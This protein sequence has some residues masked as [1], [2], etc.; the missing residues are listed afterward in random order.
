MTAA[1]Q[2]ADDVE[3]AGRR[4]ALV[5]RGAVIEE[6]PAS[7]TSTAVAAD[8]LRLSLPDMLDRLGGREINEL[9]VEAGPR[10]AGAL[11]RQ[12]LVDELILYVAPKLLGPQARPLVEMSELRSLPE[13]P[14]FMVVESGQIGEDVRLRLRPQAI[15]GG[16]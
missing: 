14:N 3:L 7:E 15:K 4:A 1:D 13:A 5:G 16:R 6:L 2:N 11:L 10:L 9:W 12:L 8:G